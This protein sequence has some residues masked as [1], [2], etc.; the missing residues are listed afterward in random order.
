MIAIILNSPP[1]TGGRRQIQLSQTVASLVKIR[2]SFFMH[3]RTLLYITAAGLLLFLLLIV[4]FYFWAGSGSLSPQKYSQIITYSPEEKGSADLSRQPPVYS[5]MTYNLGYLSGMTNNLPV[6]R[7]KRLF[8]KNMQAVL[9]SLQAA[10]PDFIG[11]QEIDFDSRRSFQV[12]QLA[13]IAQKS[14]FIH[15]ARAVNWDKRYVP[16]PYWPPSVH[17]GRMLSGQ[18]VLSR[19]P[20]KQAKRTRLQ[21]DL[22]TPF[23]HRKFTLDRLVQWVEIDVHPHRLI[24]LNVHLEAYDP[25]TR[26]KQIEEVLGLYRRYKDTHPLLLI[27]DFNCVPPGAPKKTGFSDEPETDYN[28]ETTIARLLAEPGLKAAELTHLTFP[29]ASP[30]RKLDYIF[31]NNDKIEMVSVHVTPLDSS[32]HYPVV[33]RFRFRE[34]PV[35]LSPKEKETG[36]EESQ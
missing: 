24:I 36:R 34:A 15:A 19:Y 9:L 8:E 23:Y 32:D 14:R 31:Y 7:E 2:Y 13:V 35:P 18:A 25:A 17:F 20:I 26:E 3:L 12:N 28:Q 22:K 6:K 1:A 33:M 21:P 30:D 5:I 11:F 4:A 10:K 16:Y 27:G 29:S